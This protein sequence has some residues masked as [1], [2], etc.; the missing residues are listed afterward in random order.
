MPID[1]SSA[2]LAVTL[3]AQADTAFLMSVVKPVLLVASIIPYAW[4]VSSKLEPDTRYFHFNV[5]LWN[6][7][8]LGAGIAALAAV[9]LIPIF[10]V[11]WPVAILLLAGTLFGYWQYRDARVPEERKYR[12]FSGEFKEK[13]EA[14]RAKRGIAK[15]QISF[16][17]AGGEVRNVPGKD[18]PLLPVHLR[19]EELLVPALERRASRID[20]A[21]TRSGIAASCLIDGVRTNLA[22]LS[23]EES[24]AIVDYVKAQA[25]L[26]VQDR[27]RRQEADF[28]L[29]GPT[30]AA[31]LTLATSGSSA[32]QTLR[33]DFNRRDRLSRPYESLGL[34]DAQRAVLDP[35]AEV[36]D[37]HGVVLVAAPS[38]QGLTTTG[39]SLLSRH[40]AFTCNI[41][42]LEK[43]VELRLD[44]IDHV[45][46]DASNPSLPFA[47]QLQ[48]ILRRDPDIVMVGDTG[49]ANAQA[50][51]ATQGLYGPLVYVLMQQP[52]VASAITEWCR[53]VGDLKVAVKPLRA[54]VTQRLVRTLCPNC[55]QPF[56]PPPEQLKKLGIPE[57]AAGRIHRAVGKIQPARNRIE[58]CPVCQGSGYLGQIAVFEVLPVTEEIRKHLFEGDLKAAMAEARRHKMLLLPEAALAKVV[59]GDTSLEEFARVFAP[60]PAAPRPAAAAKAEGGES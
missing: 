40:D 9:V 4:V 41:K 60:K 30:G 10:W 33:I 21:P 32:G 50:T 45:E 42:T 56:Q 37:R 47:T 57:R 23:A 16:V 7:L 22:A 24:Q 6:G 49:E 38:G 8:F 25:G 39:Y 36:H 51:A 26:D 35:L 27:R 28:S 48:S 58:D 17:G 59:S 5:A 13:M 54:V 20:I 31:T 19:V 44:G 2:S 1:P 53:A 14:R 11:G 46:W 15:A 18:D 55:K 3:A 29:N 12:P 52:G 34:L 43:K